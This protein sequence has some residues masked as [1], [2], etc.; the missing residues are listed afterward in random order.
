MK[1]YT[2]NDLKDILNTYPCSSEKGYISYNNGN[3]IEIIKRDF[4]GKKLFNEKKCWN[5]ETPIIWGIG[6]STLYSKEA[7]A[8]V[9]SK[10]TWGGGRKLIVM[11]EAYFSNA[12]YG[13]ESRY[14][15]LNGNTFKLDTRLKICETI[16]NSVITINKNELC[17]AI[18]QLLNDY[19]SRLNKEIASLNDF[20]K[21]KCSQYFFYLS[22]YK[23]QYVQRYIEKPTELLSLL[24]KQKEIMENGLKTLSVSPGNLHKF[25]EN[26]IKL[27]S[28]ENYSDA[29][30]I[31]TIADRIYDREKRMYKQFQKVYTEY[32]AIKTKTYQLEEAIKIKTEELIKS[33][34]EIHSGS[35]VI[36]HAK[37]NGLLRASFDLSA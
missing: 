36:E 27:L 21:S 12:R 11:N 26:A 33:N 9:Q 24:N 34:K 16:S 5:N 4:E 1:F 10:K 3:I 25:I 2:I 15:N 20:F 22:F 37:N 32:E 35:L 29:E 8:F 17:Q 30:K 28:E 19:L 31:R 6:N 13:I 18:E 7:E 14:W 23:S